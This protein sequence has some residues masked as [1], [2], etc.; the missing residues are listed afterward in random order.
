MAQALAAAPKDAKTCLAA[1]GW[2]FETGQFDMAQTQAIAALKADDKLV[3][4]KLLRG[5]HRTVSER[6]PDRRALLRASVSPSAG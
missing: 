4:A 3:E 5:P 2:A 1:A 6:V